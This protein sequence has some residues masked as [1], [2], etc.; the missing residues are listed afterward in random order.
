MNK[1][2]KAP[3]Y[4]FL[5][6]GAGVGKNLL[7]KACYQALLKYYSHKPGENPDEM[8]VLLYAPTVKAAYNIGGIPIHAAFWIPADQGF[9]YKPLDMQELSS[10]QTKYKS[11]KVVFI[12]EISM[13]GKKMFNYINLRLQEILGCSLPFGDLF[14]ITFGDLFQLK[15]VFDSLISS[16]S[17]GMQIECLGPNLWRDLFSLFELNEIMRQKDDEQFA[18]LLKRLSE[19]F[20]TNED[21]ALLKRNLI[22]QENDETKMLPHLFVTR[23]DV[24]KYNSKVFHE[25]RES[26]KTIVEAID[27]VS[28]DMPVS[29]KEKILSKVPIDSTKTKGLSKSLCLAENLSSELTVN[30]D[31]SDGLTNGTPCIIKKLDYRVHKK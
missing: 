13:V 6:G 8:K 7:L 4:E 16:S 2:S 27:S 22:E 9:K 5:T 23:S 20:H 15:P 29:L 10:F 11:L 18:E 26:V 3:I 17:C 24:S 19:G 12:D 25:V 28:S 30:V 1:I 14:I 21:I 31:I